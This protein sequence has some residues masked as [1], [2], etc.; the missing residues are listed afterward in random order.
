MNATVPVEEELIQQAMRVAGLHSSKEV[1]E[2]ALELLITQNRR[3]A[4]AEAFGTYPWD[5]DLD[6]MRTDK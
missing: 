4:L 6:A 1:V 3:D 5:G 2:R